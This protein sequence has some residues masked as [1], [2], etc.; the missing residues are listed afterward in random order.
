MG[1][2][3]DDF[4]AEQTKIRIPIIPFPAVRRNMHSNRI[5]KR[6]IAKEVSNERANQ[7]KK[8][9]DQA[10]KQGISVNVLMKQRLEGPT[11]KLRALQ[12]NPK[13]TVDQV[14]AARDEVMDIALE[15]LML[16]G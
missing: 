14:N 16:F 4:I 9:F 7:R 8:F 3:V 2:L 11:L 15:N 13:A 5:R 12:R 1:S 10:E 6:I